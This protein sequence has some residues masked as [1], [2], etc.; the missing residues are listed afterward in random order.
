MSK[1]RRDEEDFRELGSYLQI[2]HEA[3]RWASRKTSSMYPVRDNER[4]RK[5]DAAAGEIEKLRYELDS[6]WSG[7]LTERMTW[8]SA[9]PE[10]IFD[11]W[12]EGAREVALEALRS[13]ALE[14]KE[15]RA[16]P[17]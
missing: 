6:C 11:G 1:K 10:P 8:K 3:L 16:Q 12:S 2:A 13:I 4:V 14:S 7:E 15:R 9:G 17:E 5:I